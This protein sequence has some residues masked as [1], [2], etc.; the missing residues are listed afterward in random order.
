MLAV[1]RNLAVVPTLA[2]GELTAL[3]V[4]EPNAEEVLLDG[5]NLCR[6]VVN[7]LLIVCHIL[8]V[9]IDYGQSLRCT[10]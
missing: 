2:T 9:G 10:L 7:L 6:V 1:W 4:A 5:R 3:A 8:H